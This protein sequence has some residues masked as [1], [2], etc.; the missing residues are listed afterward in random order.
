MNN[1]TDFNFLKMLKTLMVLVLFTSSFSAAAQQNCSDCPTASCLAST[2]TSYADAQAKHDGWTLANST[3]FCTT[4]SPDVTGITRYSYHTITA[5]TSGLIG[6]VVSNSDPSTCTSLKTYSLYATSGDC[7]ASTA[8]ENLV[9]SNANGSVLGNPEWNGLTAGQNYIMKVQYDIA[10][11]CFVQDQ[12]VAVYSPPASC[13]ISQVNTITDDCSS[14]TTFDVQFTATFANDPGG[15]LIL[16]DMDAASDLY[17]IAT[18]TITSPH[19]FTV[20]L[21]KG[22]GTTN[23]EVYFSTDATCNEAFTLTEPNCPCLADPGT[24]SN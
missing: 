3:T 11:S 14:P 4:F 8:P 24:I 5:G 23:Y 10:A 6:A 1:L 7:I 16:R 22:N 17:T 13:S 21:N 2:H 9:S 19:V 12:C 15:N 18:G 20:T